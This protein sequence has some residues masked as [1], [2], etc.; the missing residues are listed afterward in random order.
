LVTPTPDK[1]ETTSRP[2]PAEKWKRRRL[3]REGVARDEGGVWV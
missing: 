3:E 1:A 2:P